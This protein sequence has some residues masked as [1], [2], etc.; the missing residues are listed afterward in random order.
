[1]AIRT[2][3]TERLPD[4]DGLARFLGVGRGT[5]DMLRK[6]GRIPFVRIGPK[7]IRFDPEAVV[8]ALRAEAVVA[9]AGEHGVA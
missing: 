6:T 9:V 4:A 3:P 5:V 1:M 8:A 7:T 2:E